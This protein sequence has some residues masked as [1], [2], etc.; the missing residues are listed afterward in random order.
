M[1]ILTISDIHGSDWGVRQVHSWIDELDPELLIVC[2]DIT[3]FGPITFARDF[4]GSLDVRTL[5]VPGNCDPPAILELLDELKANLHGKKV[6][7]TDETFVGFGASPPTPFDTLFEV[8]DELIYESLSSVMER[9]AILVT[10]TPPYG[11]LD[12]TTFT[13][14]LGSKSIMR[15]IEKFNPKL[16]VFGH[17]H[18]AKGLREEET[19]YLNPGSAR[20]GY[21]AVVRTNT[22]IDVEMLG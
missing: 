20:E 5:A 19:V 9:N 13:G 8:P 16:A 17:I 21:A 10:H 3:H 18:E 15:I 11:V 4:F 12:G 2:G 1:R 6:T 7:I 14:P 22:S